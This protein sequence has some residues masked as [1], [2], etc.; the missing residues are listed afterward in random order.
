MDPQNKLLWHFPRRRLEG[1]AIR[2]ALLA[3]AGTLNSQAFGPP[4]VPPLR[5]GEVPDSVR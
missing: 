1:E 5:K 2:D 4:V 3:C